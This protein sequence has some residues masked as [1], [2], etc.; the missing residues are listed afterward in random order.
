MGASE[1][2]SSAWA[3]PDLRAMTTSVLVCQEQGA[4][5]IAG[6][7][8]DGQCGRVRFQNDVAI[9]NLWTVYS[10]NFPFQFLDWSWQEWPSPGISQEDTTLQPSKTISFLKQPLVLCHFLLLFVLFLLPRTLFC[11]PLIHLITSIYLHED[12]SKRYYSGNH[13]WLPQMWV[14]GHHC[15][16]TV[17]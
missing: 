6:E 17:L 15:V 13:H 1:V 10:W 8:Q 9:W 12:P 5:L 2:G 14:V 4:L 11:T 3:D 7:S 16:H